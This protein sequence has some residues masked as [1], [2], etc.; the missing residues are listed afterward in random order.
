[1]EYS[2]NYYLN[3]SQMEENADI[4]YGY[5]AQY[6]P[7]WSVNALAGM[8]G[9]M[10]L[11]ST[12]NPGIWQNLDEGNLDLGYGLVQWTPAENYLNW[13][14]ASGYDSSTILTALKRWEYELANGIQYY[15]TSIYPHSFRYFL[16]DMETPP[17]DLA[18]AFV[19]NY[20]RPDEYNEARRGEYANQW[21]TFLTGHEPPGPI[22]RK[23]K[24]KFWMYRRTFFG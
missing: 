8:L 7:D 18:V 11:E 13:C 21:Y 19:H 15:P 23:S 6:H 4:L 16:T 1:M 24:F 3:Q 22:L 12:V 2:G 5:W 20:E 17:Y 10:Q 9:N 14:K